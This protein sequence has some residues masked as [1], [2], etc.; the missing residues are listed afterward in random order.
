MKK[1]L[2]QFK[3]LAISFDEID[4]L[5]ITYLKRQ[6]NKSRIDPIT[7]GQENLVGLNPK[8]GKAFIANVCEPENWRGRYE[9]CKNPCYSILTPGDEKLVVARRICEKIRRSGICRRALITFE[10]I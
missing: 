6:M 5:I 9:V 2:K 8:F 7:I 4:T 3:K 10:Y 1:L